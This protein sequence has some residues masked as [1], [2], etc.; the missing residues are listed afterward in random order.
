MKECG[1]TLLDFIY[2]KGGI[3]YLLLLFINS[4]RTCCFFTISTEFC[5]SF[6]FYFYECYRL[7]VVKY[8][9]M[10]SCYICNQV[11]TYFLTCM[12]IS[13]CQHEYEF[14]Q[15]QSYDDT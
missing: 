5:I 3:L 2:E 1:I 10:V 8:K 9:P 11:K 13:V 6:Y 4:I 15:G 7:F 12:A 14:F